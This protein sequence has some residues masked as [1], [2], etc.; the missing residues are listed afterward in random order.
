MPHTKY[1]T[2][3]SKVISCCVKMANNIINCFYRQLICCEVS[4]NTCLPSTKS[5]CSIDCV[6]NGIGI[7]CMWH[8]IKTCLHYRSI[9]K[10]VTPSY[11]IEPEYIGSWFQTALNMF[12]SLV[13]IHLW[14]I[15]YSIRF[16]F[17][18][19]FLMDAMAHWRVS[20]SCSYLL[21]NFTPISHSFYRT[22]KISYLYVSNLNKGIRVKLRLN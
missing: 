15:F 20:F 10:T 8:Y 18:F 19:L 1:I 2:K 13:L 11:C 21:H 9:K 3:K 22:A 6:W 7:S 14:I 4:K 17:P 5:S 12:F 16:Y